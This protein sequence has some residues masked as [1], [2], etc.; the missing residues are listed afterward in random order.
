[1]KSYLHGLYGCT[2]T[3][4][5]V[6]AA[7]GAMTAHA[8]LYQIGP[9]RIY[10]SLQ[11]LNAPLRPG[12]V[13]EVDGDATYPGNVTFYHGGTAESPVIIRGIRVN[14]RRPVLS[15]ANFTAA[16][17][18]VAFQAGHITF[19]GF[20]ID[21]AMNL[22][23]VR[24]LYNVADGTVIR[25]T[26]V[27][28]CATRGIHGS[29]ISGS[30]T[31]DKV[32]VH[33]CGSGT[34]KHQ[35]Y[36]ASDNLAFPDA[37]FRMQFC[38][39]HDGNGGNNVKSRVGRSEIYYNW[40]EGAYYHELDLIGADMAAQPTTADLVREDAD[41]VGNVIIKT[42]AS[43][44]VVA[45]L[46]D[47]GSGSSNGRYRLVNNTVVL[48]D[49][50]ASDVLRLRGPRQSVE[51]HNNVFAR[52]SGG[53]GQFIDSADPSLDG[54]HRVS[55]ANNLLPPGGNSVPATLT[56]TIYSTDARFASVAGNDFTPTNGS[57]LIDAGVLPTISPAGYPFPSPLAAPKFLPPLGVAPDPAVVV[58]RIMMGPVDLGAI[59]SRLL[60]P[61]ILTQP[62]ALT[63]F[64][65]QTASFVVQAY[66]S[67]TKD[68]P[69]HYQWFHNGRAILTVTNDRLT[70]VSTQP[71]DAGDY[72]VEV[73]N[74]FGS[75]WSR[76]ATLVVNL[77]PVPPSVS[78]TWPPA[79]LFTNTS[80][81]VPAGRAADDVE[82]R[83]V[84]T[85]VNRT[86]IWQAVT[87]IS[88]ETATTVRWASFVTLTPG[89]NRIYVKSVDVEGNES[90][91]AWRTCFYN[92]I[93]PFTMRTNGNG[94]ITAASSTFGTPPTNGAM[95]SLGGGYLVKAEPAPGWLFCY[96]L[97][98]VDGRNFYQPS[99]SPVYRFMMES[100]LTLVAQFATNQFINSAGVFNGLF[101][102]QDQ[103]TPQTAGFFRM[104]TDSRACYTGRI[105][106]AGETLIFAGNFNTVVDGTTTISLT[107]KHSTNSVTIRLNRPP[108]GSD[109]I[110]GSV[111]ASDGSWESPLL[112]DRA[113]FNPAN[114][115]TAFAGRY[116]L[117]IPGATNAASAPGGEGYGTVQVS[118]N[119]MIHLAGELGDGTRLGQ[120]V[121]ISKNGDWPFYCAAYPTT[122]GTTHIKTGLIL[123]WLSIS[124]DVNGTV[125]WIKMPQRDAAFYPN[126]FSIEADI[127]GSTY[128][129]P[130]P[131]MRVTDLKA[132]QGLL[133]LEGGNLAGT[134]TNSVSLSTLNQFT[135][136]PDHAL[137]LAI[138][139][140]TGFLSGSFQH[141]GD[142]NVL[143]A[144]KGVV[145]QDINSGYGFF[146]G[147]NQ[148]GSVRLEG[149]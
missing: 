137:K 18:V 45:R 87:S 102:Q 64:A 81:L 125:A 56:G 20:E 80:I 22:L 62:K 132:G 67:L 28:H 6:L 127:H 76:P 118:I 66:G 126:G 40:I 147:T 91:L 53:L 100:N 70:I 1:M 16:A 63:I 123:G 77:D 148:T 13:V 142:S 99:V 83:N 131:G 105:K 135:A 108:A 93:S 110:T 71:G 23:A 33:H 109:T 44:G 60:P 74:T 9:A 50:Y 117:V 143:K 15:G 141:P 10:T 26:L 43:H 65:G 34:L 19:E 4:F 140:K 58:P 25:D 41:I 61:G 30:L 57:P 138:R 89:T 52:S 94:R 73:H 37:V 68:Y 128:L 3:T 7:L 103:I 35:I 115:A 149:N 139:L 88:A 75:V 112:A 38:Y 12:D 106:L 24:G 120:T 107:L 11:Q 36:V 145:L 95:L 121:A 5:I 124:N 51:L 97:A 119:G 144:I 31:L 113:A 21:G 104:K 55:G 46:G 39:I 129:A 17:N 98:S 79:Y 48:P 130:P 136:D 54:D 69:L 49:G 72:Q 59:E 114:P 92:V 146:K 8:D 101:F 29:D 2:R 32:E 42:P 96:W 116:T 85:S 78:F 27:H 47:D 134:L 90:P 133:V 82:V 122:N 111:S 86:D 14:G 84:F